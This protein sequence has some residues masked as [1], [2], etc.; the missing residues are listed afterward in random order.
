MFLIRADG[1]AKIGAGHLVR[2]MTIAEELA[3]HAGK[4]EICFVC[5]DAESADY[6]REGGLQAYSLHTDYTRMEQEW[7]GWRGLSGKWNLREGIDRPFILVDSYFVTDRYLSELRNYGYVVLMDD[8]GERPY[9]VDCVVN[10]NAPAKSEHYRDLY[11]GSNVK[12]I[13][14]SSY[15]P[16]RHQFRDVSYKVRETVQNVL[17]TVGGGDSENIAGRILEGLYCPSLCFFVVAGR[18]QPHV[19][20][21]QKFADECGNVHVCHDVKNMAE[22][23]EKCDVAVTAGGSTVYELASVGVPF[24]CFSC[25][26]NQEILTTYIK[27]R[28]IA[29]DAGAWHRNPQ[30]T[31]RNIKE[32]FDSLLLDRKC[33]E[34]LSCMERSLTDG[35]GAARL[36]G[37]L[38][39]IRKEI[40]G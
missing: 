33:R 39:Q 32:K 38:I 1:N 17:I 34:R 26:D 2:C 22:L 36:A 6:V 11:R 35:R 28:H 31:M 25:A 3:A 40:E 24:I 15:I 23:M 30:R 19:H 37:E 9:P 8:F 13:I 27:D 4:N 29:E 14:G 20:D 16:V 5:A 7:E 12:L 18:F 21:L 10:Y